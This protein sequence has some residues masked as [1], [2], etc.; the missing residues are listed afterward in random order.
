M[1]MQSATYRDG[2]SQEFEPAQEPQVQTPQL[3]RI[4]PLETSRAL[5]SGER[6]EWSCPVHLAHLSTLPLVLATQ[7]VLGGVLPH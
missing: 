5:R 1:T 6:G 7:Q 3:C 2:L 4:S